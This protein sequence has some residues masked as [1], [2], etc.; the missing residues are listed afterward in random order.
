MAFCINLKLTNSPGVSTNISNDTLWIWMSSS[1]PKLHVSC[2]L[3]L[4]IS[5]GCNREAFR[6]WP[7]SLYHPL[8]TFSLTKKNQKLRSWP[9]LLVTECN[10]HSSLLETHFYSRR[11]KPALP[12]RRKKSFI[13]HL[14]THVGCKCLWLT[15]A[16]TIKFRWKWADLASNRQS[17]L[18]HCWPVRINVCWWIFLHH[19]FCPWELKG[20]GLMPQMGIF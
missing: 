9:S 10:R 17:N 16:Q 8:F 7:R 14:H 15:S 2:L 18:I 4:T 3:L 12:L 19:A 6:R 20:S 13:C 5:I 11:V 1:T